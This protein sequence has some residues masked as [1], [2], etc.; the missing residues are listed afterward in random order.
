M[1]RFMKRFKADFRKALEI[2][3]QALMIGGGKFIY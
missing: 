1:K 3:G 2:Y